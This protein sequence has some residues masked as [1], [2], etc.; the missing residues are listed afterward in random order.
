MAAFRV[1]VLLS[2][3]SAT[4][5]WLVGAIIFADA[6]T[7]SSPQR[8][9]TQQER[10]DMAA[11]LTRLF[12]ALT[13]T[14]V[15][16]PVIRG[17]ADPLI[18]KITPSGRPQFGEL[19]ASEHYQ[20][21]YYPTDTFAFGAYFCRMAQEFVRERRQ[22]N[23][24]FL[25][26]QFSPGGSA[27]AGGI[28]IPVQNAAEL[29]TS[30][31]YVALSLWDF[32]LNEDYG[33]FRL[34]VRGFADQSDRFSRPVPAGSPSTLAYLPTL[35]PPMLV[36]DRQPLARPIGPSY[37]NDDLPELRADFV[38]SILDA[39]LSSCQLQASLVPASQVL[40]GAVL[41]RRDPQFRTFEIF[42]YSYR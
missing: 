25:V 42:F 19:F 4:M 3:L 24:R 30:I 12:P 29:L 15:D 21:R 32:A 27:G 23:A 33:Q 8:S 5:L 16:A 2:R 18:F 28:D 17:D 9:F 6:Q 1:A 39:F 13:V 11:A 20:F 7:I 22:Q 26:P 14:S 38:K 40:Q 31:F 35:T 41:P 10:L 37:A 34:L 36:Y